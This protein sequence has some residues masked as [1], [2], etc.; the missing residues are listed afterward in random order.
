MR[1]RIRMEVPLK[2]G[3]FWNV[4]PCGIAETCRRSGGTYC[5]SLQGRIFLWRKL[6]FFGTNLLAPML[7]GDTMS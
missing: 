1:I 3:V 2:F 5:L 6:K 4:T 7:I